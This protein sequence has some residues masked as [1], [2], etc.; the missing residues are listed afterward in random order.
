[1]ENVLV[2]IFC[3]ALILFAGLTISQLSLSTTDTVATAWKQMEETSAEI[4]RTNISSLGAQTSDGITI[5]MT[6][7]NAGE[8]KLEDFEKWDVILQYHDVSQNYLVKRLTY[9]SGT[10]ANNEWTVE[11]IYL[12]AGSSTAEVFDPGIFNPD[13]EMKIRMVV[14][15]AVGTP[16]ANLATVATQNG[17]SAS[18]IFTR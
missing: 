17:V 15:P 8:T 18:A 9:N 3:I 13:E 12:N 7:E 1:M 2:A 10:P 4:S 5:D 6:L 11:G 14:S 16:N